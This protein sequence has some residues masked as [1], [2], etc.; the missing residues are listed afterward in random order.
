MKSKFATFIMIIMMFF[1]IIAI[2]V[3]SM[4]FLGEFSGTE[5][6]NQ[7][8]NFV[9]KITSLGNEINNGDEQT[10]GIIETQLNELET[11]GNGSTE[12]SNNYENIE[13]DNKYFY[14]QLDE[15]SK[16][17]YRA[18]EQ[19]KENMKSGV[20]KIEFGNAFYDILSKQ[21]G[22]SL[23]G[24]YYQSAIETYLYDNPDVFYLDVKKMY[25][26]IETIT[27]GKKITYNVY[28]NSG[29]QSNYLED[30]YTNQII[31]QKSQEI[32]KVVNNVLSKKTG[33]TYNDI[34]MIHDYLLEN[35]EYETTISESDI[36][37]IYGALIKGKAVCEGYAKSFQYFMNKLGIPSVIV[38]G[39]ATNSSGETENHAWNYVQINNVWYAVDT[40]WDDPIVVGGGKA[41][42]KTKYRYF[43]KGKTTFDKDHFPNGQFVPNGKIYTYPN[44][45]QYDMN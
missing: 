7:I 16:I 22:D 13:I 36:Y 9:S 17:F 11:V 4:I 26:N 19:N 6:G 35:V 34:K 28:I 15:T 20:Y 14:N 3:F 31:E 37:N 39:E 42:E 24:D 1:I 30:G 29:N 10:P 18:L 32:Q 45:S 27:R 23:L 21:D 38:I 41:S 44:L 43:L 2:I 25:L 8:D 40:T 5:V 12:E 33:N